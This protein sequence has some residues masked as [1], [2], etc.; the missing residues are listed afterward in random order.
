MITITCSHSN[1]FSNTKYFCKEQCTY[2][3]VLVSTADKTTSEKYRIRDEG[4]TFFVTISDLTEDDSGTYWC[5][6]DR[7]GPDTYNKV[8]LQVLPKVDE[9]E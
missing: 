2:E 6:I 4:N 8:V 1:A 9:G 3:D 5:G 7:K